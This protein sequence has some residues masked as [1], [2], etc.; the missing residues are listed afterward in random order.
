MGRS[1]FYYRWRWKLKVSLLYWIVLFAFGKTLHGIISDLHLIP[2]CTSWHL[3]PKDNCFYF[4]GLLVSQLTILLSLAYIYWFDFHRCNLLRP[5]IPHNQWVLCLQN[6]VLVT[7]LETMYIIK[8]GHCR[9]Q[10]QRNINK[11]N[12]RKS[13]SLSVI[14]IAYKQCSFIVPHHE[15]MHKF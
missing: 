2:I 8:W 1:W 11:T 3:T 9:G 6:D 10:R 12:K 5:W 14:S 7:N 15:P 13:F 4:C